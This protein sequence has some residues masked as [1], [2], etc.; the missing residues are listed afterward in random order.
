MGDN[1]EPTTPAAAAAPVDG[2]TPTAPAAAST[3]PGAAPR[4]RT[5]TRDALARTSR[6]QRVSFIAALA[7]L[8][9]APFGGLQTA[10]DDPAQQIRA[11]QDFT[12]GP[13]EMSIRKVVTVGDLA[14]E[15]KPIVPGGRLMAVVVQVENTTTRPEPASIL[16]KSVKIEGGGLALA[17]GKQVPPEVLS[18]ADGQ[19]IREFNPGLDQEVALV[20][21]QRPGWEG[22]E[23][24]VQAVRLEF[25]ET[26]ALTL[27]EDFWRIWDDQIAQ[28][29]RF[30]VEVRR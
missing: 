30:T 10:K 11:G 3:G 22:E 8:A 28:R 5:R 21:Q 12:V 26:S 13:F 20:F 16:A 19:T 18:F 29:G 7:L 1:S 17:D 2:A 4:R 27:D 6:P 25:A 9:T 24:T 15:V 14:P 23:V